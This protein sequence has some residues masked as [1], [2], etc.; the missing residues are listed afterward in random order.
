M[1]ERVQRNVQRLGEK[2]V[3]A[4]TGMVIGLPPRLLTTLQRRRVPD[5]LGF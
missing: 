4:F 1:G 2:G 5:D 3:S